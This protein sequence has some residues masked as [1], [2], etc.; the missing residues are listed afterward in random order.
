MQHVDGISAAVTRSIDIYSLS[1]P[2]LTV[3]S[4]KSGNMCYLILYAADA[5]T[6]EIC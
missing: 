4:L 5:D 2:N 1:I 3:N 6:Q